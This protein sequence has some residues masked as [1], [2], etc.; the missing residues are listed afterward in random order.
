[1]GD[2]NI[3]ENIGVVFKTN[4]S[5]GVH[6]LGDVCVEDPANANSVIN[7]T[8][9]G[10]TDGSVWVCLETVAD[11]AVGKYAVAIKAPQINLDGSASLGD[12]I[13]T[14]TTPKLGTP[15]APPMEA[16]DFAAVM[17]TGTSP[18]A[19]LFG[20]P[21]TSAGGG[22]PSFFGLVEFT[23]PPAS[24]WSWDN[25]VSSTIDSTAGYEYLYA[26]LQSA[27][28]VAMRYRTP[29]NS[30]YSIQARFLVDISG[31]LKG[32]GSGSDAGLAFGFRD[33]GGKYV[34]FLIW[35]ESGIIKIATYKLN[36][37]ASFSATYKAFSSNLSSSLLIGG[38]V[39]L[40]VAY[41]G[42]NIIFYTSLDGNNW[43]Q[44]DTR[45]L[46][47]FLASGTPNVGWGAYVNATDVAV[48]LVS[49]EETALP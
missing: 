36:S 38:G 21:K 42:T 47:D 23:A 40:K 8:T 39:W 27:V 19:S 49:W 34:I 32:S 45:T 2:T 37:S 30:H 43:E 6:V 48:A 28:K 26:P 11:D 31:V 17:G 4:K 9:E 20:A 10:Y 16:G 13:K 15:H 44:F 12:L 33:S 35:I 18:A 7:T 14:S 1:M 5:G 41:D 25:Q 24:G 3:L 46:T 22:A 29:A